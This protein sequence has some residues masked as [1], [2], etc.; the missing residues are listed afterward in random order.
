MNYAGPRYLALASLTSLMVFSTYCFGKS[1][2]MPAKD[3]PIRTVVYRMLLSGGR[4]RRAEASCSLSMILAKSTFEAVV[5]LR[6]AVCS[7]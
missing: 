2:A 6:L 1:M 7:V 4:E 3:Q 5:M